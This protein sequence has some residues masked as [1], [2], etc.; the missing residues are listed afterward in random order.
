M[1]K[2]ISL[3]VVYT[4]GQRKEHLQK[5]EKLM[6]PAET[7]QFMGG[8]SPNFYLV[9]LKKPERFRLKY[10]RPDG[11]GYQKIE[12]LIK[13]EGFDL[14]KISPLTHFLLHTY[15]N[16]NGNYKTDIFLPNKVIWGK[17]VLGNMRRIKDLEQ[18]ISKY[19][20]EARE[21]VG[22]RD[23]VMITYKRGLKALE[24][25]ISIVYDGSRSLRI[26]VLEKA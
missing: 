15:D 6:A 4:P 8:L 1:G 10:Y 12:N 2:K 16:K 18:K 3:A 7:S 14:S 13:E 17:K 22:S 25:E 9:E 24:R 11:L 23:R 5:V 26:D 19:D 20:D 21:V